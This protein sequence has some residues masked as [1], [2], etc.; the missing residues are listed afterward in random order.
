MERTV[1]E[2]AGFGRQLLLAAPLLAA[3]ACYGMPNGALFPLVAL[4]LGARGADDVFIG[5]VSSAFFVG[6]FLA[7]AGYA[8]VVRRV[9]LRWALS[10]AGLGGA[11]ATAILVLPVPLEIWLIARFVYGF[12]VG[13]FYLTADAWLG[14]LSS[15]RTRGRILGLG[16]SIR[17]TALA[18]GP[19]VLLI[20]EPR[21]GLIVSALVF[22]LIVPASWLAPAAEQGDG[23][24]RHAA[25]AGFVRRHWRKLLLIACC[26]VLFAN[27]GAHGAGFATRLGFAVDEVAYFNSGVY[28]AGAVSLVIAGW[29]SD[30]LGRMIVLLGVTV[31]GAA[32][33]TVLAWQNIQVFALVL[34]LAAGVQTATMPLWSMSLARMIDESEPSQLV[35]ASSSGLIAYNIGAIAGPPAAGL[36]MAELGPTGLYAANAAVLSLAVMLVLVELARSPR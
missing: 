26:G 9:G 17:M 5:W 25:S 23:F 35:T 27:I 16:E 13:A 29:L 30:R 10:L 24:G 33:A 36:A 14:G 20:A 3:G 31:L 8:A 4:L 28:A 2:M 6:A 15:L 22:A 21:V 7:A 12:S 32:C 1:G 18:A 34:L 11:L 19:L